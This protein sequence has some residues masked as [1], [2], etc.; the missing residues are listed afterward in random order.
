MKTLVGSCRFPFPCAGVRSLVVLVPSWVSAASQGTT[1]EAGYDWA[2]KMG[3]VDPR[4]CSGPT[5]DFKRGCR[6]WAVAQALNFDP[7]TNVL[8]STGGGA[9]GPDFYGNSTYSPPRYNS[10]QIPV[11]RRPWGE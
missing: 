1:E 5:E 6:N 11:F 10:S 3:I 9:T 8:P 2:K 7:K 4:R